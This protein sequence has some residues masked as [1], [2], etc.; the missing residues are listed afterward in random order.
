M[1]LTSTTDEAIRI[2]C[3]LAESAELMN[4]D[5]I[6]SV[7]G[8][9]VPYVRKIM[10]GL[11]RNE[12]VTSRMGVNGGYLLA[13]DAATITL[14]DVVSSTETTFGVSRSAAVAEDDSAAANSLRTVYGKLQK[15]VEDYLASVSIQD[16]LEGNV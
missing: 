6:S 13:R 4:A 3:L 9:P 1:Q 15:C 7:M 12:L 5:A 10:C 11:R 16:L 8:A 2:L 14:L